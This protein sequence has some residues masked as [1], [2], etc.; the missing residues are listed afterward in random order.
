MA[1]ESKTPATAENTAPETEAY[2]APRI[3]TVVTREELER[4]VHYAGTITTI[5]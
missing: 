5:G 3:E 1:E 2:E 4:E